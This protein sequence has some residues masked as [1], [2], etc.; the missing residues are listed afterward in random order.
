MEPSLLVQIGRVL[1]KTEALIEAAA[2]TENANDAYEKFW[3]RMK[4][5][6]FTLFPWSDGDSDTYFRFGQAY[7][8]F[9]SERDTMPAIVLGL[10]DID[11]P[12]SERIQTSYRALEEGP[13]DYAPVYEAFWKQR[14][15]EIGA[16]AWDK[17]VAKATAWIQEHEPETDF[18][19]PGLLENLSEFEQALM[20][21]RE[22]YSHAQERTADDGPA[23]HVPTPSPEAFRAYLA[24]TAGSRRQQDVADLLGVKQGQ[25][26][27]LVGKVR[28]WLAAGNVIPEIPKAEPLHSQPAAIDPAKLDWGA[29]SDHRVPHQAEKLAGIQGHDGEE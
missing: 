5:R 8:N 28:K 1:G 10:K 22:F 3:N 11:Y 6:P 18:S 14:K 19:P 15:E 12:S 25:V 24:V 9:R 27:K 23:A 21:A 20:E 26:S 2:L 17:A 29:R 16:E 4:G 13:V 7:E